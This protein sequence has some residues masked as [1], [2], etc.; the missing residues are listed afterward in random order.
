MVSSSYGVPPSLISP[1]SG[2]RKR[3]I[4]EKTLVL[5]APDG[6]TIAVCP[7]AGTAR[8][9]P[10]TAGSLPGAYRAVTLRNSRAGAGASV[11]AD[12]AGPVSPFSVTR[13]SIWR[14]RAAAAIPACNAVMFVARVDTGPITWN[15]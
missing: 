11:L 2:V 6:P 10:R 8:S 4:N 3:R 12:L 15:A 1:D 5:P 9:I 7:R 14:I 13:S